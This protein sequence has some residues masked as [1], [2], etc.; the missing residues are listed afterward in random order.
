MRDPVSLAC[1]KT[2]RQLY[3]GAM[4][5]VGKYLCTHIKLRDRN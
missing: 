1:F 5:K 4:E 2:Y 3:I